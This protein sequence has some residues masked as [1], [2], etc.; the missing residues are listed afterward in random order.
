MAT[1]SQQSAAMMPKCASGDQ[2][3]MVDPK[4]HMY[5]IY[6][7]SSNAQSRHEKANSEAKSND[8]QMS[9]GLKPMCKSQADAMGAKMTTTP[10]SPMASATP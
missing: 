9:A 4:T 10:A 2:T 6:A 5:S 7:P 1:V 3:V 8:M